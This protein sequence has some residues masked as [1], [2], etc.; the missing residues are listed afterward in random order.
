M[1][2]PIP[3]L[4]LAVGC[5]T[6][7]KKQVNEQ[8]TAA[9]DCADNICFDGICAAATPEDNGQP[10][11]G[12]GNCKSFYCVQG[13]C[14]AGNRP[15]GFKCLHGQACTS[16]VCQAGACLK[17]CP[18]AASLQRRSCGV[19]PFRARV[20][21]AVAGAARGAAAAAAAAAAGKGGPITTGP[22]GGPTPGGNGHC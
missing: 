22:G 13:V 16:G 18:A 15:Q 10:C 19:Y 14:I 7:D 5:G 21:L 1:A 6:A 3:L 8:C 20:A 17:A 9:S 4:I 12:H 11:A 2:A